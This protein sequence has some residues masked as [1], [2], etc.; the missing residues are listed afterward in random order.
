ML[1]EL[2]HIEICISKSNGNFWKSKKCI[3]FHRTWM[4]VCKKWPDTQNITMVVWDSPGLPGGPTLDH[5]I[6]W[7]STW[8]PLTDIF[9]RSG[10][11]P[12]PWVVFH[13][14]FPVGYLSFLHILNSSLWIPK[15]AW[16]GQDQMRM[17]CSIGLARIKSANI[18]LME[19]N[20]MVKS[21]FKGWKN[22]LFLWKGGAL[23][24]LCKVANLE[25]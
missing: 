19:I 9:G 1:Q 16:T 22:K 10:S 18:I 20:H 11:K 5:Q 12:R 15:A 2:V 8:R 3:I 14:V 17:R 21:R 23:K 4:A 25:G 6:G 7:D 24:S 13:M